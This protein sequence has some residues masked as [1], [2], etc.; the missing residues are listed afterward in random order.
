MLRSEDPSSRLLT[1]KL[2]SEPPDSEP[3]LDCE[4]I[5]EAALDL[6]IVTRY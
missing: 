1:F 4:E 6:G 3:D 5:G 2:V